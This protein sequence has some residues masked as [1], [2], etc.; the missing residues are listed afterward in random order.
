MTLTRSDRNCNSSST[1]YRDI[2]WKQPTKL[3]SMIRFCCYEKRYPLASQMTFTIDSYT[4]KSI[5][6]HIEESKNG[7]KQPEP[8]ISRATRLVLSTQPLV[9]CHYSRYTILVPSEPP[10]RA[11]IKYVR[12]TVS[13][14]EPTAPRSCSL[15]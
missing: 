15:S 13:F 12:M 11:D 9:L 14:E 8:I 3:P 2:G 6:K 7:A 5:A 1:E 10:A 4:I